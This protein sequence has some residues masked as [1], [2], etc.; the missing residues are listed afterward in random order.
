MKDQV[1][2]HYDEVLYESLRQLRQAKAKQEQVPAYVVFS[3]RALQEM[4][5]YYPQNQQEFIKINGVGPIK[6]IKYGEEFLECIC[7][8]QS[9]KAM[10]KA[11]ENKTRSSKEESIDLYQ[12]GFSLEQIIQTRQLAKSTI[13]THLVESIQE[14]ISL[15]ISRLVPLPKQEAIQQAI[16]KAGFERLAPIKEILTD[17]H[18]Y[19]D[20]RL[21][22]AFY[23]QTQLL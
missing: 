19:D 16:A 6:W 20:I 14:G 8:H 18:T 21:V 1:K 4:A 23:R 17:D 15:D 22:A 7:S 10:P 11:E 2:L 12:Q 9:T 3:D 13:L 5:V